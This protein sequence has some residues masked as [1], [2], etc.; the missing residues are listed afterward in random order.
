MN[1]DEIRAAFDEQV[2]R[3]A[4]VLEPGVAAISA[5]PGV[6]RELATPGQGLSCIT[7]TELDEHC[8]DEVIAAQVDFFGSRGE[9]FEWKLFGYDQPADLGQRLLKAGFVPDDEEVMLVAETARIA[10]DVAPPDGIRL[11]EVIDEAG[12]EAATTVHEDLEPGSPRRARHVN[13]L[14]AALADERRPMA[15][16]VAWAG[17]EPVSSARVDFGPGPDFAGLFSGATMAA[18]RGRGIYRAIVAYR[19]RLAAARGYKYLRVETSVMSRPILRRLGFE[20]V[21]VTTPYVWKPAKS[22]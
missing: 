21:G 5:A 3:N 4:S 7:W 18:W 15:T 16:V 8:A 19:A 14:L 1:I 12:V 17:D 11:V 9:S 2:R 6:L 10:T 20:P 13:R 22:G